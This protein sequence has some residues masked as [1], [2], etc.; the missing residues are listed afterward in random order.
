MIF[1]EVQA[2]LR[3]PGANTVTPGIRDMFLKRVGVDVET[4]DGDWQDARRVFAEKRQAW[5]AR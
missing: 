1:P 3:H 4:F 2:S 5:V